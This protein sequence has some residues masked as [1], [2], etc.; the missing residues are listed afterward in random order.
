MY[1]VTTRKERAFS[2]TEKD[3]QLYLY[4]RWSR[5]CPSEI[6]SIWNFTSRD[7]IRLPQACISKHAARNTEVGVKWHNRRNLYSVTFR[8]CTLLFKKQ[9]KTAFHEPKMPFQSGEGLRM[10]HV[11]PLSSGVQWTI[12]PYFYNT[13]I[14]GYCGALQTCRFTDPWPN[15]FVKY[16]KNHRIIESPRLEKTHR[17]IQSNHSPFTNGSP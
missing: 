4:I 13:Q 11:V 16:L 2:Q 9:R 7:F 5:E 12:Q 10:F 1:Q 6:L 3:I 14:H 8:N 17:I 15:F